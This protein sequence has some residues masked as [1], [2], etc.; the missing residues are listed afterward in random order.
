MYSKVSK[1][2]N[3]KKK[4]LLLLFISLISFFLWSCYKNTGYRVSNSFGTDLVRDMD[5]DQ[6]RDSAFLCEAPINSM[7]VDDQG[8]VYITSPNDFIIRLNNDGKWD[9]GFAKQGRFD[10]VS[11]MIYNY[12]LN[13]VSIGKPIS[14]FAKD[15]EIFII[16]TF[17][18][19]TKAGMFGRIYILKLNNDGNIDKSFGDNGKVI[20]FDDDYSNNEI[21]SAFMDKQGNIY[22]AYQRQIFRKRSTVDIIPVVVKFNID[23][24]IDKEFGEK[25]S[26]ILLAKIQKKEFKFLHLYVDKEGKIY[27]AGVLDYREPNIENK[28]F[29]LKLNNDLSLDRNFGNEGNVIIPVKDLLI[30]GFWGAEVSRVFVD[31][32][33]QIYLTG[34]YLPYSID[35]NS[36]LIKLDSRGNIDNSFGRKGKLLFNN[37]NI[38]DVTVHSSNIYITGYTRKDVFSCFSFYTFSH[39]DAVII[40]LKSTGEIDKTFGREMGTDFNGDNEGDTALVLDGI[41]GEIFSSDYPYSIFVNRNDEIYLMGRSKNKSFVIKMEHN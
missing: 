39:K 13:I 31:Q 17:S 21:N 10:I 8:K 28:I 41:S 23:G 7:F 15:K 27:I 29:I 33:S 9:S 37:L 14:V 34:I 35:E 25:V 20:I 11:N 4:Y 2:K 16:G 38:S 26:K 18:V 6:D 12:N 22:I 5:G 36:F 30:G 24:K 1:C 40:R 32:H 19:N 3:D